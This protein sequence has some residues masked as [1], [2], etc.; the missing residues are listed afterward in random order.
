MTRLHFLPLMSMSKDNS[1]MGGEIWPILQRLEP[2]TRWAIYAEWLQSSYDKSLEMKLKKALVTREAKGVLRRL[3]SK[4]QGQSARALAKIAYHNPCVVFSIAI[5]Q[6][7]SYDN[8]AEPLIEAL[9]TLTP[10]GYD[11]LTF[12]LLDAFSQSDRPR[13]KDDGTN[14]AHWLQSQHS[15][16]SS[17]IKF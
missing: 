13:M 14:V 1:L 8:L 5:G 17:H 2:A 12:C 15:T 9:R 10:I 11:I 3:N 4:N 6:V 7:M 16:V